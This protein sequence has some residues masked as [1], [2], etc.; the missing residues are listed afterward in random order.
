M[1]GE[2][3]KKNQFNRRFYKIKRI[4]IKLKKKHKLKLTDETKIKSQRINIEVEILVCV[5]VQRPSRFSTGL[6]IMK[7]HC[8]NIKSLAIK[9]IMVIS[10]SILFLFFIYSKILNCPLVYQIIM[11][12]P[13]WKY[14]KVC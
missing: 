9:E 13:L 7:N 11:K 1:N 5:F 12:K 14:K 2:V 10:L 8:E 3:E 4:R 6:I